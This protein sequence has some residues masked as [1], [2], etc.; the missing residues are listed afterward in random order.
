MSNWKK[1]YEEHLVSLE[2]AAAKINS[3][4]TLWLG[5]TLC[6]PYAF[7]DAL[8]DRHQELEDVTLIGNMYLAPNKILMDPMYKKSFHTISMFANVLERMAAQA[9]NIDF[10][11]AP[12]GFLVDAVT[13]VYKA[14][15]LCV[16]ICPP[17]EDGLCNVGVLGTNFTPNIFRSDSITDRTTCRKLFNSN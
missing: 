8:A 15:V 5:S 14:N 6:I 7:M 2:G 11:S 1:H 13:K 10:H 17:D 9:N 12:Y 4:D 3:G 16:E